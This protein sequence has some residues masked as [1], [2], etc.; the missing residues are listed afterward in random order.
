M[1]HSLPV[2]S[3]YLALGVYGLLLSVGAFTGG[4]WAGAGIAMALLLYAAT[5]RMDGTPPK[6]HTPLLFIMIILLAGAAIHTALAS[7]QPA[8]SWQQWLN[9]LTFL[10]PLSLLSCASVQTRV[11]TP[12]F[13]TIAAI[14]ASVG[15]VAL[16]GELRADGFLLRQLRGENASLTQYNRGFSYVVVMAFPLMATLWH[17]RHRWWLA[18]F[19]LIILLPTGLTESRSAKLALVAGMATVLAAYM[20]PKL[21]RWGLA[22]LS[23]AL[24]GWSFAARW[25]LVHLNM[26]L[27]D[28]PPSWQ[29]RMEIWDYISYRIAERPLW[30]WGLGASQALSI[31]SPHQSQYIFALTAAH[32]PH[33]LMSQL[34][35]EL[36]LFG[37]VMG[38]VFLLLTLHRAAAL[39]APLRPFAFGA[40]VAALILTLFA[41][42]FWTDSLFAAF[43]L[44]AFAF[45]GLRQKLS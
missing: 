24:I 4:I 25:A 20:L 6:P 42:N 19:F 30:G 8:L 11:F 39:P 17:R 22:V 38:M 21:T 3:R 18:A 36:G 23:V 35:V 40:W 43:A 5:W 32:H 31:E 9:L 1:P 7:T 12:R 27:G 37:L 45:G 14:I 15:A 2:L 41:Y 28:L 13:F 10:A 44:T 34:W 33:N 16:W 29:H 26:F